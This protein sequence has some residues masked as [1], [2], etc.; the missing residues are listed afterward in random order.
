MGLRHSSWKFHLGECKVRMLW[1]QWKML[2]QILLP[3][4]PKISDVRHQHFEEALQRY[5]AGRCG[6]CHFARWAV[7]GQEGV[8]DL[9]I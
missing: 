7:T 9:K 2:F 8:K 5:G 4:R 6:V 3:L 1:L